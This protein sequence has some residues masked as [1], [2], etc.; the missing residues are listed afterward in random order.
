MLDPRYKCAPFEAAAFREFFDRFWIERCHQHFVSELE[1]EYI[2]LSP[3]PVSPIKR[4]NANSRDTFN[5][6]DPNL[7][8]PIAS[9]ETAQSARVELDKYLAESRIPPTKCP[10]L[11]WKQNEPIYPHL[12]HMARVYLAIPGKPST[13]HAFCLPILTPCHRFI[14]MY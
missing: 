5:L 7:L 10:L 1:M 11:W 8:G 3:A 9:S 4:S 13:C 12:A 6:A 14:S 2:S